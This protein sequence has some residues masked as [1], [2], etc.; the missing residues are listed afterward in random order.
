MNGCT[1]T[2]R[3]LSVQSH[4]L[5]GLGCMSGAHGKERTVPTIVTHTAVALAAGAAFAPRGVPDNFWSLA[6]LCSVLPDADVIGFAFGIPYGH[7][8]GHRG[9]FHS[10][11]FALCM[12]VLV[13]SVFLHGVEAFSRT[14]F[15]YLIFFSLISASHGILDAL[16]DG[17]LGIALLSPFDNIRY[18]LPWTPIVVSPIGIRAFFSEWGLAVVRSEFLWVWLPCGVM[19]V[20]SRI[21]RMAL[22]R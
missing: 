21:L 10:P 17:G 19:V 12:G 22:S 5:V 2:S 1:V 13:T 9:F 8:F 3:R 18:F 16:T 15:L 7:F 4:R 14:W 11:F 20:V 6:V